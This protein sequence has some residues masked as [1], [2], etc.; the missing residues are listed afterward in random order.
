MEDSK[1]TAIDPISKWRF[2]G[3]F[4]GHGG[5]RISKRLAD[6]ETGLA[7]QMLTALRK[8]KG[9]KDES[10]FITHTVKRVFADFDHVLFQEYKQ[11][12]QKQFDRTGKSYVK[13]GDPGSCAIVTLTNPARTRI[14]VCNLGDSR[15][16]LV[17]GDTGNLLFHT[18]DQTPFTN[19]DEK[20]RVLDAGYVTMNEQVIPGGFSFVMQQKGFTLNG[21]HI[22]KHE[23]GVKRSLA[24][25]RA[26]GDFSFKTRF[27]APVY[28]DVYDFKSGAVICVPEIETIRLSR[29]KSYRIVLACDGLFESFG[30]K[31]VAKL[32]FA[33][34]DEPDVCRILTSDAYAG[35]TKNGVKSNDNITVSVISIDKNQ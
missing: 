31:E 4:D 24:M 26:F 1:I 6:P 9:T 10:R 5:D 14:W 20:K 33:N 32:V 25:S 2:D 17:D 18:V 23:P 27:V 22:L 34:L 11:I 8:F 30:N 29:K 3:V 35:R 7:P 15:M 19:E 28:H 12:M 21:T 16:L 13:K